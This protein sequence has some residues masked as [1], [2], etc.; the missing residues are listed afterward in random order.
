MPKTNAPTTQQTAPTT[1]KDSDQPLNPGGELG[2]DTFLKLLVAQLKYQDPM[3]PMDNTQFLAQTAQFTTVEKLN[4]LASVQQSLLTAQLQLGASNLI[5]K[6]VSYAD[7]DGKVQTGVVT[8]AKFDGT[9]PTLRVGDA[10]IAVSDVKEISAAGAQPTTS[11]TGQRPPATQ[12]GTAPAG[13]TS[14]PTQS[15]QTAPPT[16]SDQTA[17]PTQSGQTAPPTQSGQTAPPTQSGPEPGQSQPQTQPQTQNQN[18]NQNA[19]SKPAA[20]VS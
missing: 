11:Q 12:T 5:G 15:D 10:D 2:K 18:Q 8:A 14:P 4:D 19:P 20:L 6:T 3:N 7:K 16:Q 1:K 13:Q 17:P 9:T